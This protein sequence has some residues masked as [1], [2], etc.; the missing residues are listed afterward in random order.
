[1]KIKLKI[2]LLLII[3]FP[4]VGYT[5]PTGKALELV[6]L[7]NEA[8][9]NPTAFLT[10]YKKKINEYEPKFIS[11][12]E[13]SAAVEKIIWDQE[14]TKNCKQQVFGN[15]NPTYDGVNKICGFS[16]G[17]GSGYFDQEALYFLCASYTHIMNEDDKF[18]GFYMD[19]KGHAFLWGKSCETKKYLFKFLETIDSSKVDFRKINTATNELGINQMDKEMIKEINYVRQ[20]PQVYAS[21][22]S[23]YLANQSTSWAGLSK[24]E[25]EAGVELVEE[26]KRMKPSQLLYTKRCVYEAAKKHGEDCKKRGFTDHTGS[27]GSSPFSRIS[28]FCKNLTGNENIVGGIKNVRALVILLLIDSG[29]SSRGHRYNMLNPNWKYVGCYGYKGNNMYNYIQNFATD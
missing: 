6:N 14:L 11:T 18:F 17:N 13:K 27:D 8:R 7:I 10:K 24:E 15:L 5:Q 25:Y 9:T 3:L 28:S 20:Y 1:M 21:I 2:A 29:I 4:F 16:L 22:V 26:L 19:L 23:T 12:L